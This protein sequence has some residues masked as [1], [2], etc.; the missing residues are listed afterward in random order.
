[1]VTVV[2]LVAASLL[3]PVGPAHAATT[4]TIGGNGG[5]RTFD[6]IGA[7][8]GGGGNSR[9]LID[10]PEPYRS[11]ILDY[12]FPPNRGAALQLLK[13][14][15]GGDMNSAD[16]AE[17][18]I[19]HT[20]G[21]TPNFDRGYEWWL[22]EQAKARNPDIKLAALSWGA[23]LAR[24]LLVTADDRLHRHVAHRRETHHGLTID[25]IG[26]WNENGYDKDVVR[27]PAPSARQQRPGR[28]EDC[29]CRLGLGRGQ[30]HGR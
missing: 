24:R 13:V 16:G 5:G 4:V 2:V 27:K 23:R 11:Q 15:I 30:R 3:V 18:S 21:E 19:M 20:G 25:Y 12:L 14:E 6:G 8:S 26:G 28:G 17:P 22:M 9:L 29:R 10:Y 1:M 7:I